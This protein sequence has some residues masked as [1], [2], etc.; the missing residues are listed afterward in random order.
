MFLNNLAIGWH[1]LGDSGDYLAVGKGTPDKLLGLQSF[2]TMLS[3][4]PGLPHTV[5]HVLHNHC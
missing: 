2:A 5:K 4:F 1:L 3:A